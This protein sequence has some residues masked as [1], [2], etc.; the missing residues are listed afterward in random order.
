MAF[1]NSKTRI[2][3]PMKFCLTPIQVTIRI[4]TTFIRFGLCCRWIRIPAKT[5]LTDSDRESAGYSHTCPFWMVLR[6]GRRPRRPGRTIPECKRIPA[7]S[8]LV[9]ICRRAG[10]LRPP[11]TGSRI[12]H[13]GGRGRPPLRRRGQNRPFP[14]TFFRACSTIVIRPNVF[15]SFCFK[16]NTP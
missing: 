10:R 14:L 11:L 16:G 13:A 1:I 2:F 6:R 5:V 8:Q 3:I 15:Y 12:P 4:G 9:T 7:N